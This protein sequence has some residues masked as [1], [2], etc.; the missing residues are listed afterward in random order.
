M[1]SK[2]CL[3]TTGIF[4]LLAQRFSLAFILLAPILYYRRSRLKRQ[5]LLYSIILGLL[6]FIIMTSELSALRTINSSTASFIINT[7]VVFV[8]LFEAIRNEKFPSIKT[9]AGSLITFLGVGLLTFGGTFHRFGT[10][11]WL[12]LFEA[13]LYTISIILTGLFSRKTDPMCMGIMQV[14]MIALL[15]LGASYLFETPSLPADSSTWAALLMLAVIGTFFGLTFQPL[16][17]RH[18]PNET[19]GMFCAINPVVASILSILCLGERLSPLQ[20]AGGICIL[21]GILTTQKPDPVKTIIE[22]R[23]SRWTSIR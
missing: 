12:C 17:Q 1:A 20:T 16:A 8:P 23:R 2:I 11:E 9:I 7:A 22:F 10:G 14:G 5:T 19:A 3:A 21:I 13:V 15:S 6:Y 4:T 18:M